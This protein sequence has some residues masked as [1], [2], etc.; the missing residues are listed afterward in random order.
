MLAYFDEGA[1]FKKYSDYLNESLFFS[2]GQAFFFPTVVRSIQIL[3]LSESSDM[4]WKNTPCIKNVGISKQ[5]PSKVFKVKVLFM[6]N[7][8]FH[9]VTMHIL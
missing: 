2:F 9:G 5:C 6:Q 4:E 8:P 3:Y 1:S 7:D